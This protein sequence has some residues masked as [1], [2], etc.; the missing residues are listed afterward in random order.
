M[1]LGVPACRVLG[2]RPGWPLAL[3]MADWSSAAQG[4]R[5]PCHLLPSLSEPK[6][7]LY[8]VVRAGPVRAGGS[9]LTK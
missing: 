3:W 4:A 8:G 2:C 5:S 1:A 6:P 9:S 7:L